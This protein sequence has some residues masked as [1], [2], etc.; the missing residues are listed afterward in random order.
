[1][2]NSFTV[3]ELAD[4]VG[5]QVLGN[6]DLSIERAAG[7]NDAGPGC[8]TF[9]SDER[10]IAVALERSPSAIV[11]RAAIPLAKPVQILVS[12]PNLAFAAIVARF[13]ER[14]VFVPALHPTAWV[15]AT[16]S[17]HETASLGPHV[18]VLA[19]ASVGARTRLEA[20]VVLGVG[21]RVGDD[22]HLRANVSVADRCALGNR[23]IIHSSTV[24]GS[25]GFGYA[26]TREGHH[27][28]IPQVGT[29]VIEDDVEIG[30]C[31]CIDRA[32]MDETR[33]GAGTKIDNLV[34]I[35]HN[36]RIGHHCLIVSQAGIAGSSE[37]GHHVVIGGNAGVSGH[38]KIG[39]GAQISAFSGVSKNLEGGRGY[40]AVPAI[41]IAEGKRVRLMQM[42][43]P[44]MMTR[45]KAVE[46]ELKRLRADATSA[47]TSGEARGDL[48]ID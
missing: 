24:V 23:V 7:A 38:L 5:G 2:A 41:P 22:C 30:A 39:D 8:V 45:L 31:V 4:L 1:M 13:A 42:K 46:A 28:K 33:I 40:M 16:A 26:T 19:G 17:I 35:A 9:A 36:V 44:E 32:R 34:Q 25:D 29:V 14:E 10:W 47:D 15:D 3:R 20:G 12:D 18:T 37:L 21:V 43:L 48:Q 6:G 27:V 11:V